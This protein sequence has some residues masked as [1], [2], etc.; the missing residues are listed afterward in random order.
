MD[1][2]ATRA[3]PVY[4]SGLRTSRF[5]TATWIIGARPKEPVPKL[6]KLASRGEHVL[7]PKEMDGALDEKLFPTPVTHPRGLDMFAEESNLN[8]RLW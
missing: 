4:G 5:A 7:A 2:V 8:S 1:M 3:G 6:P